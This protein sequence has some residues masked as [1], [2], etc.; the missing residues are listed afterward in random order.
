MS[1]P[2][3]ISVVLTCYNLGRYLDE[4]VNSVLDQTF[5]DFEILVVDD[6]STEEETRRLLADYDRP[7]TRVI[8]IENR[9]LP[10][11]RNAG[12]RQTS[13]PYVCALDADDRLERTYF[14]K[15]AAVL[16]RDPSVAFVSHWLRTFGEG[17]GADWTPTDADFPVLLDRNT[18]NGAALVRRDALV[19]TGLFDETMR[20]GCEDW[21]LWIGM[22][23]RGL[24]GVI[25]P[26]VLFFYRRRADSMSRVMM[27]GD[28][29]VDLYRYIVEKHRPTFESHLVDLL[30]RRETDRVSML[31]ETHDLELD[32]ERA[33]M[34]EI[35]RLRDGLRV[36]TRKLERL[37]QQGGSAVELGRVARALEE[38]DGRLEDQ[39][40]RLAEQGVELDRLAHVVKD[41]DGQL[42]LLR[43]EIRALRRSLS[44][45][46][47]APLRAALAL[48][49]GRG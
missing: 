27:E 12:I 44:W 42:E 6:G 34:P 43:V 36:S 18:I 19:A 8:H 5:Q 14:E 23:E 32:C 49:R 9:G 28:T 3:K 30:V 31:R 35:E 40:R 11:A 2:P 29:H 25:L 47:T 24:R 38:R 26:E 41:R 16:D 33:L 10:G 15:A 4:A 17:D 21:D 48:F 46:L 45:R 20:Q 37:R 22:V 13:G 1:D 39:G 7:R